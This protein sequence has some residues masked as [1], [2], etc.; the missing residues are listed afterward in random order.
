MS[1]SLFTESVVEKA[2]LDYFS[3]L[4]YTVASGPDLAPN[5]PLC[6]RD[7]YA[8][9]LLVGRLRDAIARLNPHLSADA[10]CEALRR[11]ADDFHVQ[12]LGSWAWSFRSK[13]PDR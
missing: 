3:H 7:S 10:Q 11:R 1:H 8:A 13:A 2:A 12:T 6:A 4:G 5:Q 9:V